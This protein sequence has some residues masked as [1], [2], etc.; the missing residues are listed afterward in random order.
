MRR[1]IPMP[2][3]FCFI[4]FATASAQTT[5]PWESP[6]ISQQRQTA[7][8]WQAMRECS[9]QAAQRVRDHTVE[10]NR[11]REAMRLNCLRVHH[12]PVDPQ[13]LR[14]YSPPS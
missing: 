9:Q 5:Q 3:A 12:L 7:M 10:G 2:I 4:A 14:T 1:S 6:Y 11:Q 13:P 8:I